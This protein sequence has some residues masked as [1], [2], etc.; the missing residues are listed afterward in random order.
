[1][2]RGAVLALCFALASCEAPAPPSPP[3]ASVSST[4][5]LDA[6][7]AVRVGDVSIST[8][9][10][11]R[12]A[13]AQNLALAEAREL[14]VRDALFAAEAR[15]RGFDTD[16]SVDLAV[17]ALLARDLLHD[18][19]A[20]GEAQGPV[21]DAELD[22]VTQRH[23]MELDCPDAARVVHAVVIASSKAPDALR[24]RTPAI[25]AAIRNAIAP[26]ASIA[27]QTEPPRDP[28]GPEDPVI[29]AFRK[30]A[31]GVPAEG[32]EV[33]VEALPPV[34]ADGRTL[35]SD[36]MHLEDRFARAAVALTRRGDVSPVIETSFGAHVLLLLERIPGHS[37]PR[38]ERRAA[39]RKEV[40][41]GRAT[42]G[43]EQLM[44]KLRG[45]ASID[46]SVDALLSLVP[47]GR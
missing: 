26:A 16:P 14:A 23:W 45:H 31:T 30:A 18:I 4:G 5:P 12:I 10:V 46:R 40:V 32:L 36:D 38:E 35:S 20:A 24:A 11:A 33:R 37:V 15:A 3:P 28:K 43:K 9:Q 7:I 27:T 8:D 1:M 34:V 6:T 47:V 29:A 22:E 19:A 39:V 44:A 25:A 13:S 42:L 41:N 2:N 21:T 17:S